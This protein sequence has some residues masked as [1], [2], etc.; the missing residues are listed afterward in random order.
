M[1]NIKKAALLSADAVSFA[2]TAVVG[3]A[4]AAGVL[5]APAQAEYSW[6]GDESAGICNAMSLVHSGYSD[7]ASIEIS[8]LQLT[9]NISRSEAVAGIRQAASGYC[10]E[11]LSVVPA[12]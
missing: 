3:L 10:P 7:W 12:R 11:Y 9:Q 1:R 4:V 5:A 6:V 2:A 8:S